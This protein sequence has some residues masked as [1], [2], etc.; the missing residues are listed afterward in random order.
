MYTEGVNMVYILN[1][2]VLSI[3]LPLPVPDCLIDGSSTA[4]I[5]HGTVGTELMGY[6]GAPN[7]PDPGLPLCDGGLGPTLAKSVL[8]ILRR[9]LEKFNLPTKEAKARS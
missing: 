9:R 6:V 7:T 1:T 5:P 2:L 4:R 3:N 8:N